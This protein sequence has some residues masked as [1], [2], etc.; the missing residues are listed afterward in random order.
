MRRKS[1]I[2]TVKQLDRIERARRMT[3]DRRLLACANV[4]GAVLELQLS[5]KRYR[6]QALRNSRS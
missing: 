4:S 3:P 6:K 5:G 2:D 1:F